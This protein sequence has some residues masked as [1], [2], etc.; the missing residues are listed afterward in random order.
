MEYD[1]DQI[2]P[3][4]AGIKGWI[5]F[6]LLAGAVMIALY[7]HSESRKRESREAQTYYRQTIK[8]I[9]GALQSGECEQ[10]E[11]VYVRSKKMRDAMVKNGLYYNL[12]P[13]ALQANAIGIAECFAAQGEYG[14]ALRIVK[15][16]QNNDPDFLTRAKVI[17]QQARKVSLIR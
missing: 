5:G 12:Y 15:S 10:A 9:D 4:S 13:H 7:Y 14:K 8:S 6:A 1:H 16:E 2:S 11:A 17:E 3:K